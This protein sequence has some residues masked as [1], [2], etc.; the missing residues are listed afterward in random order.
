[1]GPIV[2]SDAVAKGKILSH[3]GKSNMSSCNTNSKHTDIT[4]EI[5]GCNSATST[6]DTKSVDI[7]THCASHKAVSL[8]TAIGSAYYYC[9]FVL[10]SPSYPEVVRG[11]HQYLQPPSNVAE[12][13]ST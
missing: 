12:N 11:F 8:C 4:C 7:I 9:C 6:L 13:V 2:G 5:C 1:V 10:L 3:K